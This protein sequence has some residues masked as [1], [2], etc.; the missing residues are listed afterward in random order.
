[1]PV[2]PTYEELEL[3]IKELEKEAIKRKQVE[4]PPAT[5]TKKLDLPNIEPE[6]FSNAIQLFEQGKADGYLKQAKEA[7]VSLE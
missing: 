5:K 3:R 6:C 2:K 4:K 7:L 1:M